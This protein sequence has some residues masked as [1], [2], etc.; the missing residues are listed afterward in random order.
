[1]LIKNYKLKNLKNLADGKNLKDFIDIK[2]IKEKPVQYG[3]AGVVKL[4]K[5]RYG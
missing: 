2:K 3:I 4:K 1:M 5:V